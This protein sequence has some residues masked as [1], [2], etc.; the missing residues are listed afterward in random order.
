MLYVSFSSRLVVFEYRE[1]LG[2]HVSRSWNS[3]E[4]RRSGWSWKLPHYQQRLKYTITNVYHYLHH[5]V[6]VQRLP[7]IRLKYFDAAHFSSRG[8]LAARLVSTLALQLFS[9]ILLIDLRRTRAL[10]PIGQTVSM[11]DS[12]L[13][14]LGAAKSVT[15][16]TSL[17]P[18][19]PSHIAY[20]I[21]D[22]SHDQVDFFVFVVNQIASGFLKPGIPTRNG[23]E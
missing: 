17:D 12:T 7:W 13:N 15:L 14:E 18:T 20:E 4:F 1:M 6:A 8:A 16:M 2:G 10:S 5:V 21:T 22:D 19:A 3:E 9:P 11:V 23:L